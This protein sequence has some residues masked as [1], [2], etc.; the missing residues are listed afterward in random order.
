MIGHYL[1]Y[2]FSTAMGLFSSN[3]SLIEWPIISPSASLAV[4]SIIR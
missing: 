4:E 3:S 1:K 2:I